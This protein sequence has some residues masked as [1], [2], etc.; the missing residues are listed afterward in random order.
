MFYQ[1]SSEPE[2]Y[3][4]I[5]RV[6][7]Y[8]PDSVAAAD[9]LPQRRSGAVETCQPGESSLVSDFRSY[10]SNERPAAELNEVCLLQYQYSELK[11]REMP[12]KFAGR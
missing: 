2:Q 4:K 3:P 1:S 9:F 7:D 6:H 11:E 12:D 10:R 5:L 8:R